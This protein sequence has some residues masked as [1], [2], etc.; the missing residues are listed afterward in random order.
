MERTK[1][2]FWMPRGKIHLLTIVLS[3]SAAFS[4]SI[5]AQ[6]KTAGQ[7]TDSQPL[8]G[9]AAIAR[10]RIVYHDR[11]E[12]CHFSDSDVQKIGPGLKGVYRRGKFAD[13]SK[14]N[15]ASMEKWI[16]NGSTNMPP[17]KPV[18]NPGQFRDLIAYLKTL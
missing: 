11:C 16:L 14:V 8:G 3:V 13:G 17:F 18:L 2:L 1:P 12:I 4:G 6:K 9:P 7:K 15:D 10:G 5:S